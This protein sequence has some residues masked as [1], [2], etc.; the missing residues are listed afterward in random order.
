MALCVFGSVLGFSMASLGFLYWKARDQQEMALR[1][2]VRRLAALAAVM[3]DTDLHEQLQEP[4]QIDSEIYRR[5]VHP[6]VQMHL[7]YPDVQYIYTMRCG[8]A[9]QEWFVLDT[10]HDLAVRQL[11]DSRGIE[12]T[13][14]A[15]MEPY[16]V[17]DDKRVEEGRLARSQGRAY[18]YTE[19]YHDEYGT[20]ISAEAP[21]RDSR[22][23]DIG[24]AG[25]DYSM[26][27]FEASM[28]D[29]RKTGLVSLGFASLLSLLLARLSYEMRIRVLDQLEQV[30]EAERQARMQKEGAEAA[31]ADKAHLLAVASHDLRNPLAAIVGLADLSLD[32]L[33]DSGQLA[34]AELEER[35][36]LISKASA[37]MGALISEILTHESI[38]QRGLELH[39]ESINV[40]NLVQGII[41]LNQPSAERKQTLLQACLE[42]NLHA[43]LDAVRIRE[44]FDN[45]VSNAIKYGP[46]GS[47]V[48]IVLESM[49]EG[50]ALKFSVGDEGPGI[51]A[52]DQD[53]LFQRFQTLAA[54]PSGGESSTGL[55]LSIVKTIVEMHG[56]RVGC[57]SVVGKGSW[58]WIVLPV[59]GDDSNPVAPD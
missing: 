43:T 50:K 34:P 17:P 15:I 42:A 36:Q 12:V 33:R 21:L 22:G 26:S 51:A 54:A 24:Y 5:A 56:G 10:N 53:K 32:N 30:S 3:V 13:P 46:L 49:D 35:L 59:G 29:L 40:S 2:H 7:L 52:K 8:A 18:V 27:A 47:R 31:V 6:L 58:F 20:F 25:V 37:Q 23:R 38:E 14:S 28:A 44:A 57:D 55:G 1:D 19:P 4:S 39:A 16:E 11:L 45:L 9:G 41:A 48:Q